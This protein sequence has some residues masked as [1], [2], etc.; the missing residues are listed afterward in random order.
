MIRNSRLILGLAALTLCGTVGSA[1]AQ[2][3]VQWWHA[4][5]G[6]RLGN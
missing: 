6:A 1:A 4:M 3:E 5:G 2:T